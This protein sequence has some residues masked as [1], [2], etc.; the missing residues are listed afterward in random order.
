MQASD[1]FNMRP[2]TI[3]R[4]PSHTTDQ[5][6]LHCELLGESLFDEKS[7]AT[8]FNH[9]EQR[10][11]KTRVINNSLENSDVAALLKLGV[12]KFGFVTTELRRECWYLLLSQQLKQV[13]EDVS[14]ETK[15]KDENQVFLDV[16]RSFVGVQDL[17][18]REQLRK[19]LENTIVRV[20]RKYPKLNYY[21]G[22]H[23]VVSV[24]VVVFAEGREYYSP[25]V[26]GDS[27]VQEEVLCLSDMTNRGEDEVY[28]PAS[29]EDVSNS[30]SSTSTDVFDS[31][32]LNKTSVDEEKLFKCVE[33]FTLL[34]LR[35][36]MM[37]SLDFPIDQL[38]IIPRLV[39]N[40]DNQLYKKLQLDKVEPFFAVSSILTIFSHEI[41]PLEHNESSQIF[42]IFDYIVSTQSMAVPLLM[43]AYLV[44]ENKQRLMKEYDANLNNFENSIDLVHGVMQK[45]L[46][47]VS[48][49]EH[50]WDRILQRMRLNT[51]KADLNYHKVVNNCSVL[52]TTA[53]GKVGY[54]PERSF[55]TPYGSN[56][57]FQLLDKEIHLND[58][59]KALSNQK[60][61]QKKTSSTLLHRLSSY[62][63]SSSFLYRISIVI[64]IMAL[65]IKLHRN[66]TI[67]QFLPQ[68]KLCISKLRSSSFVGLYQ[69][70][71]Y[72]WLDP[73]HGLLQKV[74]LPTSSTNL[75]VV[76]S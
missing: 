19:L 65:L 40:I 46:L 1:C 41:K 54:T 10:D 4:E 48:I 17:Q 14:L 38:K 53:S 29:T 12:S 15:H 50:I 7:I 2:P 73:L 16:K 74:S 68:A 8:F 49:D 64:G 45:V 35:D 31:G 56:Y 33:V 6:S 13:D 58:K 3:A 37:D 32:V 51:K 57:V 43:Y 60:K 9:Q 72:V 20:L 28:K 75:S 47:S 5:T 36:F 67:R 26:L 11:F 70:S 71:K 76:N 27:D 39:K 66:G 22:Y 69:E 63:H 21:Q 55:Q 61:L 42:S 25:S 59:R 18:R 52:L 62:A 44:V 23:D 34:Y 30:A 24:F